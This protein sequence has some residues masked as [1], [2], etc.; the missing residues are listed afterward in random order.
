[1]GALSPLAQR[2]V[3][4]L[5]EQ[6]ELLAARIAD[7]AGVKKL[8]VI[9]CLRSELAG[10]VVQS[11]AYRWSLAEQSPDR[12]KSPPPAG[13]LAHL[14]RYYLE[15]ISQDMDGG[16]SVFASSQYGAPDYAGLN[17]VSFEN[18]P[19]WWR[20]KDIQRVL[21]K[22]AADR[23]KLVAWLGYPVR[24]RRHRT[25]KWEG[26]FAE[27][28][29]LWPI[30]LPATPAEDPSV[31]ERMPVVNLRVIRG[32][33]MGDTSGLAEE[34][35]RLSEELGFALPDEE[36]PPLDELIERLVNV[37][38]EWDWQES[39]DPTA[40]TVDPPLASIGEPGIYNRAMIVPGERSPYTQG[41]E[42]ELKALA[43]KD[44]ADARGTALSWWLNPSLET[45][46]GTLTSDNEEPLLEVLPMNSEQRAAIRS[47][48]SAP[49]TVIT[50]PPGTGK[51]QVVTNLLIN[52]A[53]RGMRVLFAS[54]NNKAVDVVEARVNGLGSR[55]ILL[56]LGAR[57]LQERLGMYLSQLL[58]GNPNDEERA[59]YEES[60]AR[61]RILA[62]DNA[63][64][65]KLLMETMESR[66]IADKCDE[67]AVDAR[68]VFGSR[69][70]V[71]DDEVISRA[72]GQ[73]RALEQAVEALDPDALG[74]LGRIGLK[75]TRNR[76]L[77][78]LAAIA[79]NSSDTC[80]AMGVS[81]PGSEAFD[82]VEPLRARLQVLRQRVE[83]A[84][85]L[86]E[87]K[88]A[89]DELQRK[90][91]FESLSVRR[92]DLIT[93]TQQNSERLWR[94]WVSLAPARLTPK[95]RKNIAEFASVLAVLNAPNG[96]R[97]PATIRKR[98]EE[99]SMAVTGA[100]SCWAVTSLSARGRIP[101]EPGFFDLVVFDEA[102][103][104]DIASALPLLF[105]AKRSVVIGDPMQ[106]KH[107][108]ALTPVRDASLQ[109]KHELVESRLDWM[110]SVRSLYDVAA[111][112][113]RSES[114]VNLRDHHRSH[115]DIIGF[116]N[117]E[118]YEGRL[119]VATR[120]DSLRRPRA[121]ARGV[122]WT[123]VRGSAARP[124]E[125][126][127]QNR[128]E[129]EALVVALT[130]LLVGH[131]YQG[132][133]GVVTPFRAQAQLLQKLVHESSD[134]EPCIARSDLLI[135]TVHRFQG[136]ERDVMFFSPVV[137][138]GMSQGA[139]GFLRAN[140]NLF[141]VAITRA[142]GLL[143]VVGD[144]QASMSSGVDYLERFAAY[145]DSLANRG[146]EPTPAAGQDLGPTYPQVSRPERVSDWERV[147]YQGMYRA[148]L[149]PIPQFSVEQ[150]DLDFALFMGK[151]KLAIEVDG[152]RYHR[153]WTGDLVLRDQIRNMRL[154]EL[155]WEVKRFW[156]PEV[157]D[158]LQ[159]CVQELK[160]WADVT[161]E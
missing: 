99:L 65:D 25:P 43:G 135:D 24:L 80:R 93:R 9:V 100:L 114:I 133:V 14:S 8:D 31:D 39:I 94:E 33:A 4:V 121:G 35:A 145:V 13:E 50:G 89:F 11:D 111:S 3:Q 69:L 74:F 137:A 88:R 144:K 6:P 91:G 126:G 26:F 41:L 68:T 45:Q 150:Y 27:P 51:S 128:S 28:V 127:A 134:L 53:W 98:A 139:L 38:S 104:C 116:S 87:A 55:P 151:R 67:T 86:N 119:R 96:E 153:S 42:T 76:R 36:R 138:G 58:A 5:R 141:N 72:P 117:E 107:I 97:V 105:R 140:G 62:A 120:Y 148:G 129:A 47:A 115:A 118:F 136:D 112:V 85:V 49:H 18:D 123:D 63:R 64:L 81:W 71:P 110:Y 79:V 60:L 142:R 52:A 95:D 22:V 155:G 103:Q 21:G 113:V 108:S 143:H 160:A 82:G 30:N 46:Y 84:K 149:R 158:D 44:E 147:L 7:L 154:I 73:L 19:S 48:L 32:F 83:L 146:P 131:E 109:Q 61:H 17:S 16:V 75:M 56:R 92:V 10:L 122:V 152:E 66:N 12:P 40:C 1:M 57:E 2:I 78:S 23:N 20:T 130:E 157:R 102:S 70:A 15:C 37:R 54:K 59:S 124:R 90:P 34:C 161:G 159:R 125:G 101:L 77:Q 106:L 29:L 132:S 156:V